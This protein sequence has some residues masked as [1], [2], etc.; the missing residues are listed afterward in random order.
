MTRQQRYKHEMLVRVR[1][2]GA[3]H[4][5]LFPE[6]S[7]GGSKFAQVTA[8]VAA[9]E[10]HMKNRVLG[11]AGRRGV[12]STTRAAVVKYMRTLAQAARRIARQRRNQAPFVPPRRKTLKVEVATARAFL[13]EA[14]KRQAQ[15][16][17]MG[18][19]ETFVSDFRA[20]V[21]E[22]DQAVNGR[23]SGKTL[24]G[25]ARVG[26][27]GALRQ[28]LE[29]VRDLDLAVS[30]A[31]GQDDVVLATW[32]I[33]R[34]IEGQGTSASAAEAAA[35]DVA[36]PSPPT[37]VAEPASST[38]SPPMVEVTPATPEAAITPLERAS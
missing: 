20:L 33:A 1:D 26:I 29:L 25:Q 5:E 19:P 11:H 35:S 21:D 13:E 38:T 15:F 8:A 2:F 27:A 16:I 4:A 17:G 7:A 32:R 34:R 31:A 12:N 6:S 23:L 3:A 28:G 30:V 18:L 37:S 10:D 22:L 24:R 14:E 36:A 9:I